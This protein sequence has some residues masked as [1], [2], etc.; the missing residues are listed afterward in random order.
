VIVEST[1][2]KTRRQTLEAWLAFLRGQSH[3]LR[4]YPALLF[5]Q[6]INQP[7]ESIVSIA[8]RQ[9]WHS[10]LETRPWLRLMNKSQHRDPCI[11]SLTGQHW[12]TACAFS[13]DGSRIFSAYYDSSIRIWNAET[14][15][16]LSTNSYP[17][18]LAPC[19][20]SRD[21]QR[22][23]LVSKDNGTLT[24][25][26]NQEDRELATVKTDYDLVDRFSVP[27]CAFSPD[28]KHVA[29]SFKW[30]S[31]TIWNAD[32]G[33]K[34]TGLGLSSEYAAC[35][36]SPDGRLLTS[37]FYRK[38]HVWDIAT[39]E[40]MM[41][42]DSSDSE[43]TACAYSPDGRRIICGLRCGGLRVWNSETGEEV[44]TLP[45]HS[46]WV[47]SC[48]YSLN[49]KRI[50]SGSADGTVKVWDADLIEESGR[51]RVRKVAA[52][53]T[54][55]SK[56]ISATGEQYIIS[57]FDNDTIRIWNAMTA[58]EVTVTAGRIPEEPTEM[59]LPVFPM[60]NWRAGTGEEF[61]ILTGSWNA[62]FLPQGYQRQSACAY[63]PD[64]MRIIS[65]KERE[66]EWEEG[67]GQF[68]MMVK[69]LPELLSFV[70]VREAEKG[71]QVLELSGHWKEVAACGFSPDGKLCIA[72]C[73]DYARKT[74]TPETGKLLRSVLPS[75]QG[76]VK[77]SN[78]ETGHEVMTLEGGSEE[79]KDCGYSPDGKRI[80]AA[81]GRTL[82]IWDAQTTLPVATLTGHSSD[83]VGC[84]YSP[85]GRRIASFSNETF[86]GT[87]KV[88]DAETNSEL[89]TLN[90]VAML[91]EN[92]WG[93]ART[94]IFS[95]DGRRVL[96]VSS[97]G[98]LKL[99]DVEWGSEL[100]R[101]PASSH[102]TKTVFG[103]AGTLVVAADSGGDVHLL[104]V[105]NLPVD[106]PM[107]T[108]CYLFRF[109]SASLGESKSGQWNAEP[110][111]KCGWCGERSSVPSTILRAIQGYKRHG[112]ETG[113]LKTVAAKLLRRPNKPKSKRLAVE[114]WVD[115]RLASKCSC[116]NQPLRFNPF[117]VDNR[118]RY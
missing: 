110:T 34:V 42:L 59:D 52:L 86:G 68:E 107:V 46:F 67:S 39:G 104:K 38:V 49:G 80:I 36:Y 45:G 118:D 40:R 3:S 57:V 94:S 61:I 14:G 55:Y 11:L 84:V 37:T 2:E 29:S 53:I 93:S 58:E 17:A 50:I 74:E 75:L 70:V 56:D 60:L 8:A 102:V 76:V 32:T 98:L 31:P 109:E 20:F 92:A 69:R 25:R 24:L 77:V 21:G 103:R 47:K 97:D 9:R 4:L 72:A 22:I 99:W 19:A 35:A 1:Y 33:E 79:L 115:P 117:I 89:V 48:A 96:A 85:D 112:G 54:A 18:N 105:M 16:E 62:E 7:D 108:A 13:P 23:I 63:S 43:P 101:F 88:W 44:A 95:P 10:G 81:S 116:C 113:I 41:E 12:I 26:D 64:G 91:D 15:E 71:E 78:A 30:R 87:L 65:Q 73:N 83:I 100:M 82:T 111:A 90:G 5:Q 28:G 6:A 106:L 51:A 27:G 114:A 66:I